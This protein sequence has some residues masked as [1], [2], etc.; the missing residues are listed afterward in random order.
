MDDLDQGVDVVLIE[1]ED[2]EHQ[3]GFWKLQRFTGAVVVKEDM[4]RAI[5]GKHEIE[6]LVDEQG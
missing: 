6:V 5:I 1:V 3:T 4:S 2:F